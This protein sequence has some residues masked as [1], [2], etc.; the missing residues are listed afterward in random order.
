MQTHNPACS[1]AV[2]LHFDRVHAYLYML[3]IF[4]GMQY[5]KVHTLKQKF[6]VAAGAQSKKVQS[7]LLKMLGGRVRKQ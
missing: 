2:G 5:A 3:A 7:H 4:W 1:V 6:P